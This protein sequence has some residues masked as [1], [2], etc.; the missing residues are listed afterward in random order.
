MSIIEIIGL[1]LKILNELIAWRTDPAQAKI[2]A[3][4]QA[5]AS[6]NSDQQAFNQAL[7]NNDGQAITLHFDQLRTQ[8]AQITGGISTLKDTLP[9][10]NPSAPPDFTALSA[11][12]S[13]VTGGSK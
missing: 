13:N 2:R 7:V 10:A 1:V 4:A 8:V 3:A 5:T 11:E 9:A 6:L 12:I